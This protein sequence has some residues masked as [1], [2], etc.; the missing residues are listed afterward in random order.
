[1]RNW[2]SN[3]SSKQ[4]TPSHSPEVP[5]MHRRNP[6]NHR[7]RT[8]HSGKQQHKH[9]QH[10]QQPAPHNNSHSQQHQTNRILSRP[11]R[12]VGALQRLVPQ[13]EVGHGP[14]AEA[15][16][17]IEYFLWHGEVSSQLASHPPLAME[18]RCM[19]GSVMKAAR[20]YMV[21]IGFK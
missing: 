3:L 10:S 6:S 9:S 8:N 17:G 20:F 1:M 21:I 15:G 2:T 19:T 16:A 13:K 11:K 14:A 18:P 5:S 12:K 7:S 4:V